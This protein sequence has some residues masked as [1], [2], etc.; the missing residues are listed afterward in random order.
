MCVD[1]TPE[2]APRRVLSRGPD[3][4]R[5]INSMVTPKLTVSS[6]WLTMTSRNYFRD[7]V[8]QRD[9][10]CV[11]SGQEGFDLAPFVGLDAA[12]IYPVARET[13]WV[14]NGHM[15]WITDTRPATT[16]GQN[17]LFSPQ[18]G[19]LLSTDL[20]ILFGLFIISVNSDVSIRVAL[21]FPN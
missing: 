17:R 21:S 10:A 5:K 13:D 4:S 19:L 16:I 20:H 1:L 12:H 15:S 14:Q 6:S 8:R 7:A 11:F 3:S 2:R 9:G 18:N